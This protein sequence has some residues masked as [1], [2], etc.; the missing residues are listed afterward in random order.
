MAMAILAC[1]LLTFLRWPEILLDAQFWGEDGWNWWPEARSLGLGSLILPHTGY[2]QTDD[3]IV[4][5]LSRPFS[6]SWGPTVFALAAFTFEVMPAALLISSRCENIC[7]SRALRTTIALFWC[8]LPNT[9]EVHG[10]LTNSQW[11][12]AIVSFLILLSNPPRSTAAWAFDVIM[13]ALGATSG[14]FC[15]LLTPIAA[16]V[17]WQRRSQSG[18]MRASSIRLAI[19]VAGALVQGG[20]I[21]MAQ[22]G[23]PAN[24][25]ATPTNLVRL[26]GGQVILATLVGHRHIEQ[27]YATGAWRIGLLPWIMVPTALWL[28]FVAARRWPAMRLAALFTLLML[29]AGLSHPL[30]TADGSAVWVAMRQPDSGMRY[31]FLPIVFWMTVLVTLTFAG[32]RGWARGIAICTLVTM[33]FCGIPRDWRFPVEPDRNFYDIAHDFDKAAPGTQFVIP[34]RPGTRTSY[35]K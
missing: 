12:L 21:Y 30:A 3:R 15:I 22:R 31:L 6:L 33:I 23:T 19:L 24:L 16:I 9:W 8:V 20:A 17:V 25:G 29:F 18:D 26:I 7:S 10:N 28:C 35:T 27:W 4:A 32:P 1:A 34:V 14:P 2:F 11:H 5:L 13:L